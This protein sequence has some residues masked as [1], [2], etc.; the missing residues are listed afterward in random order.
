MN[1]SRWAVAAD[2]T[3]ASD[4][5]LPASGARRRRRRPL[6]RRGQRA[7]RRCPATGSMRA[8]GP[9]R[10]P[11]VRGTAAARRWIDEEVRPLRSSTPNHPSR[12]RVGTGRFTARSLVALGAGQLDVAVYA[13][14][15]RRR[16]RDGWRTSLALAVGE[17][18]R[19]WL[20]CSALFAAF[21]GERGRPRREQTA[22]IRPELGRR[23]RGAQVAGQQT[24]RTAT[25]TTFRSA[26]RLICRA[27]RRG[28]WA[29][30]RRG[31]PSRP[32]SR[33]AGRNGH[34]THRRCGARGLLARPY[35]RPLPLG[36]D[37][38]N[39]QR[40]RACTVAVIRPRARR[41]RRTRP[42]GRDVFA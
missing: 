3:T 28:R 25:R 9:R 19:L 26:V 35:R 14:M 34:S 30:M 6:L 38:W 33:R 18:L 37:R 7:L 23:Q 4:L 17:L 5:S 29:A 42:L 16:H 2:A 41:R 22:A 12:D 36:H 10:K 32:A 8:L 39:R 11:R 40:R 20:G 24:V 31:S 13:A 1:G 21:G 27:R 15:P